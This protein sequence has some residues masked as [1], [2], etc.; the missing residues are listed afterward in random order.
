[1]SQYVVTSAQITRDRMD[2]SFSQLLSEAAGCTSDMLFRT[3][4]R[5]ASGDPVTALAERWEAIDRLP[6]GRHLLQISDRAQIALAERLTLQSRQALA[7]GDAQHARQLARQAHTALHTAVSATV[8]ELRHD[9][10][11]AV[12]TATSNALRGLGYHVAEALGQRCTGLWAARGHGI[13]AVLVQ[14]G[15]AM[16]IDNAG[17]GGG[18]CVTAMHALQDALRDQGLAVHVQRRVD[19]GD[20][21]GGSLIRRAAQTMADRPEVGL[22]EQHERGVITTMRDP[23]A[24]TTTGAARADREA[25]GHGRS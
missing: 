21:G 4:G 16:E 22:V 8:T 7:G 5:I 13:L 2:A 14:D 18:S 3:C 11:T 17:I 20:H 1:M 19:H 23:T 6:S 15:G 24:V 9:E 12:A 10:R 25:I